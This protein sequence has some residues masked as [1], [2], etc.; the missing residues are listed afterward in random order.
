ML[1]GSKES[2]MFGFGKLLGNKRFSTT[3]SPRA[4]LARKRFNTGLRVEALEERQLLSVTDMTQ[5]AQ[6]FS[7]HGGP[8]MVYLNFD[9][10]PVSYTDL[11][12]NTQTR[13][14][15]AF[16]PLPGETRNNDISAI[17]QGV[18][19]DFGPFNVEVLQYSGAGAYDDTDGNTTVFIGGDSAN[20]SGNSKYTASVT[21]PDFVDAPGALHGWNHA[22]HSDPFNLAFVDPVTGQADSA[23]WSTTQTISKI[24]SAIAHEVGHTF[25][26]EH[27]LSS[28]Q[29]DIMSYDAPNTSFI[30]QTFNVTDLNYN[31]KTGTNY[32]AGGNFYAWWQVSSFPWEVDQI[33]TQN[34][35]TYL[36]AVLGPNQNQLAVAQDIIQGGTD[37]FAIGP[38][39]DLIYQRSI[40]EGVNSL[41]GANNWYKWQSLGGYVESF[42]VSHDADGRL[43][44]FAIGRDN[45]V[46]EQW[47]DWATGNWTGWYPKGGYARQLAVSING[48]GR[49]ELFAIGYYRDVWHTWQI[50]ANSENWYG[51]QGLGGW[52]KQI[53]VGTNADGR[54]ELFAI[55]ADKNLFT[56]TDNALL[57]KWENYWSD[58][59]LWSDWDNLGGYVRQISVASNSDGRL[60]VFAIGYG[61]DLWHIWQV[62]PN[63]GWSSWDGLGGYEWQISVANN[64][65]GRLE[66]FAIGGQF[67]LYHLWETRP[68]V[69]DDWSGW[70]GLGGW[71]RQLA[72]GTDFAGHFE[73]LGIGSDNNIYHITQTQADAFWAWTNW[74]STNQPTF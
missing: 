56:Y 44:V 27:V 72:V 69:S 63:S 11:G 19:H 39:H 65:D 8:T 45:Q 22:P 64:T 10:G 51:W 13:N 62:A 9:G 73:V 29:P 60:E 6:M 34:S 68:G 2:P 3:G 43:E 25:G 35:Y 14:I 74:Y 1:P 41:Y 66:V 26:L 18:S 55:G 70:L 20:V 50:A 12:G 7:A 17:L 21:P 37:T 32:N 36:M 59:L 5:L 57:H 61:Y 49:L 30:D 47:Q 31:P 42:V 33:T 38:N 58:S 28:P 15:S 46:Y 53:T 23:T 54:L 4:K 24:V 16:Q 52:V 67:D 48:D 40:F 71:T